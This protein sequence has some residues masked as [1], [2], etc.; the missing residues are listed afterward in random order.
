MT[1]FTPQEKLLIKFLAGVI[2]IGM[3][4][5]LIRHYKSGDVNAI[6]ATK[7]SNAE[8]IAQVSKI[9]DNQLP[10]TSNLGN[11]SASDENVTSL[12]NL[13]TATI[14]ELITL[15]K[16]G[17]ITAER[18]I[19]FREDFGNFKNIDELKNIK[20]IGQKTIDNLRLLITL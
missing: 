4:V 17:P 3:I 11:N 2:V 7:E 15:P 1:A 8:F 10:A 18:I 16:I 5:G 12:I 14:E 6:S 13:N 19:R 20:G 9:E